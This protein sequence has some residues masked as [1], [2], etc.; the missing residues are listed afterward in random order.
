[1]EVY[2]RALPEEEIMQIYEYY[3]IR[4]AGCENHFLTEDITICSGELYTFPDGTVGS[5]SV[6][7]VSAL[8]AQD[9]CDS[10]ITTNLTVVAVDVSVTQDG[11]VLTAGQSGASYRW[12][13]CGNN[14]AEITGETDRSYTPLSSGNYAV[15]ISMDGCTDT[16]ECLYVELQGLPLR[17][18]TDIKLYPNPN[19]GTFT[20]EFGGTGNREIGLAITNA[21]GNRVFEETLVK[22]GTHLVDLY[23]FPKGVYF[24]TIRSEDF[25]TTRKIIKL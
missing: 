15:E 2:S 16:S 3:M 6:V 4:P 9:G 1:V 10:I 21:C 20:L 18:S 22:A 13:D 23:A 8:T 19:Q 24:I 25:V 5:E 17:A 12:L 14:C 11:G 7:Y